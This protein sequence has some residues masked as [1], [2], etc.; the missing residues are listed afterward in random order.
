MP[1][2]RLRALSA[3]AAFTAAVL[4]ASSAS[5]VPVYVGSWIVGNGPVWTSNPVS[6]SGQEAA[7]LLFGG[8]ASNYRISTIDNNPANINRLTFVDGW[9]D[10]QYLF[11]PQAD[12]FKLQLGSG[13]NDPAG[14]GTAYSAYVLDHSCGNRYD[15]LGQACSGYGEEFVNYAFRENAVPE[16]ASLL[17]LSG[18][19]AAAGAFRRRRKAAK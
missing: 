18:G 7:A 5:A 3:A 15:D 19:L 8:S 14:P 16:P 12:T 6:Y 9:A 13:Y 17:L 10:D 2:L 4:M 11:A 1:S